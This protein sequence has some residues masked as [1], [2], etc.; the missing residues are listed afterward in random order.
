[1]A[2]VWSL[3]KHCNNTCVRAA[4]TRSTA[5]RRKWKTAHA[6]PNRHDAGVNGRALALAL[7]AYVPSLHYWSLRTTPDLICSLHYLGVRT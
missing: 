4:V 6:R 5:T 2:K 3:M 1:M 7:R